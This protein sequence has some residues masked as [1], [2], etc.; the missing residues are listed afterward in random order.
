[1]TLLVSL[2]FRRT[3]NVFIIPNMEDDVIRSLLIK[4]D[5]Y[6]NEQYGFRLLIRYNH[7][8]W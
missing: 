5:I 4:I 2:P 6:G 1:M 3:G 7:Q 8:I